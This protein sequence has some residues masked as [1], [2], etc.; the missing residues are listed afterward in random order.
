MLVLGLVGVSLVLAM[1]FPPSN[2]VR[3]LPADAEALPRV[4]VAT[5]DSHYG[6]WSAG[7]L[8]NA[9]SSKLVVALPLMEYVLRSGQRHLPLNIIVYLLGRL[10]WVE[11]DCLAIDLLA[12]GLSAATLA[13]FEVWAV[14]DGR[15]DWSQTS[16]TGFLQ[17]VLTSSCCS[18]LSG[19]GLFGGSRAYCCPGCGGWGA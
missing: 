4:A 11:D 7:A 19:K 14:P 15:L 1:M 17:R 6:A 5:R 8:V 12:S 9:H 2:P 16:E 18:A 3:A 13:S 10:G